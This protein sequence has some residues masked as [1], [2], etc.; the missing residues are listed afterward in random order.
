M[1]LSKTHSLP[2][3]ALT[4]LLLAGLLL[5]GGDLSPALSSQTS[6]HPALAGSASPSSVYL[7][8]I[9]K[10]ALPTIFGIDLGKAPA[11][12][13]HFDKAL[14]TGAYWLRRG[15]VYWWDVEA[16]EGV[17]DWSVLSELEQELIQASRQ[18]MQIIL[19]VTGT[20]TW[21]QREPGIFCGPILQSK[22]GAFA[23]FVGELVS[24]Y[25]VPP[26]N[27]T[28]FEIW[29]EPDAPITYGI[30]DPTSQFG[31]WGD[32]NAPHFGGDYYGQMLKVVA[33]QIKAANPDAQVLL[34]GLLLD[35]KP[36]VTSCD[37]T[38]ASFLEGVLAAGAGPHF[39]GVSFHAYDYFP[40][41]TPALGRYANLN[42]NNGWNTTGPVAHAKAE[43][44]R[45]VLAAHGVSGKYLLNTE[46]ALICRPDNEPPGGPGCEHDSGSP[47]Q[48]TK[49]YYLAQSYAQAIAEGFLANVW[50]THLGWRDSALLHA[51][52]SP[53]PAYDAYVFALHELRN[54]AFMRQISE[55]PGVTGYEFHRG[56]ARIWVLWSLDGNAHPLTLPGAPLAVY[57]VYGADVTPTGTS[58]TVDLKPLY[59]EW[60][61]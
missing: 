46:A 9:R 45:G 35:C 23:S 15:F 11:P 36:G 58:L 28:Y 33:P 54:P 7:P 1:S 42:W 55:Y 27:V 60:N 48:Q 6:V 43:F 19:V 47:F 14:Q 41:D 8:M 22:F 32:P 56:D 34:G 29:N 25:S 51:D 24:R 31:C 12:A 18:G 40:Y 2:L 3:M 13:A 10:P 20:P 52:G 38:P 17:R 4:G 21:A 30:N 59:V 26:Y 61:P 57:D 5:L 50:F 49:A 37:S 53:F 39:D 16:T 44:V